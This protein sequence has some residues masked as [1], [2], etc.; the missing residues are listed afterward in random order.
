MNIIEEYK[1]ADLTNIETLKQIVIN[2]FKE[3]GLSVSK[4][5]KGRLDGIYVYHPNGDTQY[6]NKREKISET[7]C[8]VTYRRYKKQYC[9]SFIATDD[10]QSF[11]DFLTMAIIESKNRQQYK[12]I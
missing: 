8:S 2:K 1:D 11:E 5:I 12:G 10:I 7:E 3:N 6:Q 4:I 9:S